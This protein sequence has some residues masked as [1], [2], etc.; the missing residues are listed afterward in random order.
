MEWEGIVNILSHDNPY[1]FS[2]KARGS[3]FHVILG[4]YEHGL[5]ICVPNYNI[6]CDLPNGMTTDSYRITECLTGAGMSLINSTTIAGALR[7][8][9][10]QY[11]HLSSILKKTDL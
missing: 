3:I 9:R 11:S 7:A 10:W 1:E 4:S 2:V 8:A 6:G 5:Y